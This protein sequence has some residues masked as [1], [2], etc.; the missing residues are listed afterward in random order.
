MGLFRK[1]DETYNQQMLRE[2]GLLLD[3]RPETFA[4]DPTLLAKAGLPDGAGVGPGEWDATATAT[5]PGV[6]GDRVEFTSL[7]DGDL[8]VGEQ[9]GNGDL[10]P[11]ADAI[12]E[13]VSPPY[14]AVGARQ[15]GDL[16][17][18]AAKRIEVAQIAF[19]DADS[20]E[21]SRKDS[22]DE[23]RVDGKTSGAD[24]PP[25]LRELGERAGS[26]FFVKAERVDGDFWEVRASP[27]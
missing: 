3:P 4:P 21:L 12:E 11:L 9:D 22:W 2:A 6:S 17:G 18:V 15:H 23:F 20:L 14:K 8:I 7:P 25:R 16:W 24:V 1:R 13:S 5:A 26:D 19:P 10:S 27:L